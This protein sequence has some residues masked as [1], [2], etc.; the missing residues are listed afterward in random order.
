M[1]SV[2]IFCLVCVCVPSVSLYVLREVSPSEENTLISEH[3][4]GVAKR[5]PVETKPHEISPTE[6][7]YGVYGVL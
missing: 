2:L 1:L 7:V 4:D 5:L 6:R 3:L